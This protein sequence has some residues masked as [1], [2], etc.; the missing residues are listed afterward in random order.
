[1]RGSLIHNNKEQ[2]SVLNQLFVLI[3]AFLV[4]MFFVVFSSK[5]I[6]Q[7]IFHIDI[8]NIDFSSSREIGLGKFFQVYQMLFLFGIPALL[9]SYFL[10]VPFGNFFKI[11]KRPKASYLLFA[12]LLLFAVIPFN[13]WIIRLNESMTLPSFLAPIEA[14][15]RNSEDMLSKQM[16]AFLS[17]ESISSLLI[18]V[19]VIAFIPSIMEELFFRG[20]IQGLLSKWFKSIHFSIIITAVFFSAVHMQFYGFFPRLMLGVFL[21]YLYF[22]SGN[23]WTAI[24]F[25]FL[26]NLLS[27]LLLFVIQH[28]LVNEQKLEDMNQSNLAIIISFA[29]TA[30]VFLLLANYYS[31]KRNKEGDWQGVFSCSKTAEAE[32][33]KGKLENENITAVI[34]KKRDSSFLSFGK[35][36]IMVKPEDAEKALALINTI[37]NE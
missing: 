8:A 24:Y 12:T 10:K 13:D 23:L 14:W 11:N 3:M 6:G 21:G 9:M 2:P 35:I 26:N 32:I 15:M 31:K 22:W 36:E 17:M 29:I 18:N 27:V 30:T 25:H 5:L 34:M 19:F 20:L 37:E 4:A 28:N 33:I 1:M 7:Y 16:E